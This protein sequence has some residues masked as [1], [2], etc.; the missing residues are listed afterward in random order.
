MAAHADLHVPRSRGLIARVRALT[1]R[2]ELDRALATGADPRTT[3]PLA[4]RAEALRGRRVR[5]RLAH[6]LEPAVRCVAAVSLL[7]TDGSGPVF[8]PDPHGTL[9][10]AAFQA[11]FHAEAG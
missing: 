9:R 2:L 4:R 1:G 5:E 7:L 6:G 8:A 11:A 3:P 10:E